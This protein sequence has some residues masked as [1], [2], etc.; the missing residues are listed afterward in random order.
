MRTE[1]PGRPVA[2]GYDGSAAGEAALR[3]AVREA[4]LRYAPLVVYHAWQVPIPGFLDDPVAV[5]AVRQSAEL[6]LRHGVELAKDMAG[7]L[8]VRPRL[9]R[10]TA[11]GALL[12][13][14]G[15]AQL[16]V[17]G[18]RGVNGGH[19]RLK[20]GSTAV[21]VSSHAPGP[22]I[23]VGPGAAPPR[24]VVLLG[25]GEEPGAKAV[26]FAFEEACLRRCE[27][28]VVRTCAEGEDTWRETGRRFQRLLAPWLER[29]PQVQVRTRIDQRPP[30]RALAALATDS[31]LVVV[32]EPAAPSLGAATQAVLY[33][34]GQPVAVV[35]GTGR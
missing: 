29:Y 22:V 34:T 31:A 30:A 19:G 17:L 32:G 23:V 21:Y 8:V 35:H 26:A 7:R 1:D 24:H 27:L 3:W 15:A 14:A 10:G 16:V 20:L 13:D 11:A 18:T 4:Q 5:A 28:H 33:G 12:T 6:I 25:V 2:T 9:E